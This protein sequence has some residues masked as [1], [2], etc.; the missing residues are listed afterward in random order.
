MW[1]NMN[2]H[3]KQSL[4]L[5]FQFRAENINF[6]SQTS[7]SFLMH[8]NCKGIAL[9]LGILKV[10]ATLFLQGSFLANRLLWVKK[11]VFNIKMHFCLNR[12]SRI[13]KVVDTKYHVQSY[14]LKRIPYMN[15]GTINLDMV[16]MSLQTFRWETKL[17]V[18]K[19]AL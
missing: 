18:P 2:S 11:E 4:M 9:E 17:Y 3:T 10:G 5:R 12:I 6:R 19:L 7:F 8:E 14:I 1:L 16:L 13:D 15:Q